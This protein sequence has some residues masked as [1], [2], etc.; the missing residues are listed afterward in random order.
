[1]KITIG[2]VL[3][4]QGIKGEIKVSCLLDN[5]KQFLAL[6]EIY[7]E[8]QPVTVESVR[9]ESSDILYLK[10][11]QITDRNAAETIRGATLFAE[12]NDILLEK[13]KY[14]IDDLIG[15]EVLNDNAEL[16]GKLVAISPCKSADVFTCEKDGKSCS[17]PF[18]KS[19]VVDV[20]VTSKCITL[21]KQGLEEVI[22]YED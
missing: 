18:L 21:N 19:I 11:A 8:Q 22:I 14:F 2:K 6:K 10:L 17:F 5:S 4:A 3:K 16:I 20:D 13:G 1:M 7:V 15:C 12:K 9:V